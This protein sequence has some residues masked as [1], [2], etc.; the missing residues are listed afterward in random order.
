M[1]GHELLLTLCRRIVAFIAR[2]ALHHVDY[3]HC[4]YVTTIDCGSIYY[5]PSW[6]SH[7]KCDSSYISFM[8]VVVN[9]E[10]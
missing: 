7:P 2:E 8:D 1:K 4:R 9:V 10:Y 3:S 6:M 5:F